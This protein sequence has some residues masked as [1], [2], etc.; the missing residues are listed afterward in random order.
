MSA[1]N[2]ARARLA[3]LGLLAAG[4]AAA[5][6]AAQVVDTGNQV[7]TQGSPGESLFGWAVLAADF[8]LDGDDELIVGAPLRDCCPGDEV[9]DQGAVVFFLGSPDRRWTRDLG[10]NGENHDELGR[11]L[12]VGD[13][14]GDGTPELVVGA[15]GATVAGAAG[16]GRLYFFG[17]QG[18]SWYGAP[19]LDPESSNV[20]G[21]AEPQDGF[22]YSLAVGNFNGDFYDDL[23]VGVPWEDWNGT[24]DGAVVVLLGG[25][26][27]L[28]S[29]PSQM[30]GPGEDGLLGTPGDDDHFGFSLAVGDFNRDGR[31]DLAIGAPDRDAC[32]HADSGQ[33]HVLYG[34]FS[35]LTTAGN[36]LFCDSDVGGAA[37][38][39]EHF[40]YALAA[41]NF[42][43][44]PPS[45]CFAP[46]ADSCA[47]DLAIGVP[48]QPVGSADHAGRVVVVPGIPGTGL[49]PSGAARFGQ[50]DLSSGTSEQDDHFGSTLAVG[51]LD[52][53]P[54]ASG[55]RRAD[56][57]VVGVPD[58]NL[59][60]NEDQG[61]LQLVFGG[62]SGLG[63]HGDQLVRQRA[64]LASAPGA[65]FDHFGQALTVGDFDGDGAGDLAVGIPGRG[66]GTVQLLYGGLFADGYESGNKSEWSA[67]Q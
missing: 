19:P 37:G 34:S 58:E 66:D 51:Q 12:A 26:A 48:G 2:R 32:F 65:A 7:L 63:S 52:S 64:P 41:G 1:T 3:C 55:G 13:F 24:D 49:S 54:G 39:L 42:D 56:D 57:L 9:V 31:D 8:D 18:P 47:D 15:P 11:A 23:A 35:G 62:P 5:P 17:H 21:E 46:P 45:A 4:L 16:A 28:T 14:H 22:G 60:G 59:G 53:S 44:P 29:L 25:P 33:V 10:W 50:S 43:R 27:G 61:A 6:L 30:F 36:Q 40:G 38:V 67:S 20:P